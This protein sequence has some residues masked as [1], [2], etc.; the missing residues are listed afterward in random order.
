MK[1]NYIYCKKFRLFL[2]FATFFLS[3]TA[4]GQKA[5]KERVVVAYVTSWSSCIPNLDV[6]THI[7]Y[8]FGHVNDTFN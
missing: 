1:K 8:A 7:N 4:S 3:I 6:I 5:K 2:L